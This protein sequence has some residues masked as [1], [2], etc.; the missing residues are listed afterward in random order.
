MTAIDNAHRLF[1][2]DTAACDPPE[3]TTCPGYYAR[4]PEAFEVARLLPW[5]RKGQLALRV[6]YPSAALV[7][8]IDATES[9]L[10]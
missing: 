1:D 9:A 2:V 8:A 4:L 6:P 5:F 7:D 3:C 10:A